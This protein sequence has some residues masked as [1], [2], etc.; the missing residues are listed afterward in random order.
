MHIKFSQIKNSEMFQLLSAL[1]IFG[2]YLFFHIVFS[3][4]I[5]KKKTEVKIQQGATLKE[6]ARQLYDQEI[7]DNENFFIFLT[8][9]KF[10]QTKIRSGFYNIEQVSTYNQLINLLKTGQNLTTRLTIPEGSTTRQIADLVAKKINIDSANFIQLCEN[11][12]YLRQLNLNA[13]SVEGYLFPDTY[14][15]YKNDSEKTIIEK[16]VTNFHDKWRGIQNNLPMKGGKSLHEILTLASLIEG[17]CILDE[18]RPIVSSLY[19][20]RLKRGMKLEADPTIQYIINDSPRRLLLKDLEIDSP[21]NTYKYPGLPPGPVN[22]PGEKSIL[23]AIYP[24]E[25]NYL[26]MVAQGDGSHYFTNSYQRFLAAK[27]RFQKVRKKHKEQN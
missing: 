23:A 26:Y 17:E 16:M 27:R 1:L 12:D 2:L 6:I 24:A 15:F 3:E 4:P 20:N 11:P 10:S 18:E 25:T 21:Y 13:T 19:Q 8:R 9:L 22:S 5:Q 7:I 14:F